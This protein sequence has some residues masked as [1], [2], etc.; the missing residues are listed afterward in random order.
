MCVNLVFIKTAWV[1]ILMLSLHINLYQTTHI[2]DFLSTPYF[3]LN[4]I[5]SM[6]SKHILSVV[7]QQKNVHMYLLLV[8][9]SLDNMKCN[10]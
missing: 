5:L 8:I 10:Y 4:C 2:A 6:A 7:D 9:H 3:K 1:R